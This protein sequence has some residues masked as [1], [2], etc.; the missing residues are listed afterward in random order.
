MIK[1]EYTVDKVTFEPIIAL[2]VGNKYVHE[3]K[4]HWIMDTKAR[5]G[6]TEVENDILIELLQKLSAEDA[7]EAFAKLRE[8]NQPK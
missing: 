5:F 3:V 7:A 8:F 2:S 1:W 6:Y 4:L